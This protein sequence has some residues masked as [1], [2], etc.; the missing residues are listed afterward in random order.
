VTESSNEPESFIDFQ[1]TD[2]VGGTY[3]SQ[4]Q[5]EEELI[6]KNGVP[7]LNQELKNSLIQE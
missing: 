4:N 1:L 7:N 6:R 5:L 2:T 3:S